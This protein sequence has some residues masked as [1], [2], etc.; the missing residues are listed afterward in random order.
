MHQSSSKFIL[1]AFFLL[2]KLFYHMNSLWRISRYWGDYSTDSNVLEYLNTRSL[3]WL[4]ELVSHVVHWNSHH[5]NF[6]HK[7]LFSW[8]PNQYHILR[9]APLMSFHPLLRQLGFD[10]VRI[11]HSKQ[12]KSML[13][14]PVAVQLK[15]LQLARKWELGKPLIRPSLALL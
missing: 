12:S 11:N 2:L 3:I 14:K 10:L 13:I 6:L 1:L 4:L 7:E 8:Q 9:S 5:W 15:V